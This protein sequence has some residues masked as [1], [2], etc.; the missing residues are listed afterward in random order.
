M[1]CLEIKWVVFVGVLIYRNFKYLVIIIVI[2]FIVCDLMGC[3]WE[4]KFFYIYIELFYVIVNV[5]YVLFMF[6]YRIDE[7]IKINC[8]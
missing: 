4:W 6:F 8:F 7:Y 1:R 3:I 5:L 2:E